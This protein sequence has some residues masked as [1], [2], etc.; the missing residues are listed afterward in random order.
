M[1]LK[2][3]VS[4]TGKPGLYKVIGQNKSGFILE[5]LDEAR[6]KLLINPNTRIAAL[7]EITIFGLEDDIRLRDIFEKMGARAKELP[8]PEPKADNKALKD[9]FEKISPDHDKDRVYVSDIK[10]IVS[11]YGILSS[12]PLWE[13]KEEAPEAEQDEDGTE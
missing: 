5:T 13:E 2:G 8:V 9:Y 10:K 11:W 7:T 1:N 4:V 3:I 12:L 6:N